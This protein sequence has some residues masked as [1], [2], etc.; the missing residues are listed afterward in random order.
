MEQLGLDSQS[1]A[2]PS[3]LIQRDPTTTNG[4]T[5][6]TSSA[7][8]RR[9]GLGDV[10][11]D[12]RNLDHVSERLEAGLF[13]SA[14]EL[15]ECR[16]SVVADPPPRISPCSSRTGYTH[17]HTQPWL[18]SSTKS[19]WVAERKKR[20]KK[21]KRS[22]GLSWVCLVSFTRG[23]AKCVDG[24]WT[25]LESLISRLGILRH[26]TQRAFL[27]MCY[28]QQFLEHIDNSESSSSPFSSVLTGLSCS[29]RYFWTLNASRHCDRS[30]ISLQESSRKPSTF[31]RN[32]S[33]RSN[34]TNPS[35][36]TSTTSV[37]SLQRGQY[38]MHRVYAIGEDQG[39]SG[40]G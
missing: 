38:M 22:S 21:W 2:G 7:V 4:T 26:Q 29:Q 6:Q 36:T 30:L 20:Q 5:N 3:S 17:D 10:S 14:R 13:R 1:Q 34:I 15:L 32:G 40:K 8:E 24:E 35:P 31:Y 19:S 27:Y 16:S 37:T 23:L 25:A 9:I 28:R 12:E 33:N 39:Q 11:L 18:H